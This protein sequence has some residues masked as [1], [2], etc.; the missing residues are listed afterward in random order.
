MIYHPDKNNEDTYS[1]TK[2]NEI[3]E[4]Y[5]TLIN[6]RKKE[7]YLQKR[8][9]HKAGGKKVGEE[10]IT[11]PAILMQSLE[12]N[13]VIAGM[14]IYRMD[15][16]GVAAKINQLL[17]DEVI[18]KL[19]AFNEA[20]INQ[21]IIH[22]LLNATKTLPLKETKEVAERLLMLAQK[23]EAGKENIHQELSKKKKQLQRD[24]YQ[25]IGIILLTI[26]ICLLIWFA[27]KY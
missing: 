15:Y 27:G 23:N 22:C 19:L 8:W 3:K 14:D 24:R 12:L 1:L 9:L 21:S 7:L 13:K 5:E 18:E 25:T 16:A 6:P 4:A 11:P 2:F 10:M 17:T 26:V 20:E